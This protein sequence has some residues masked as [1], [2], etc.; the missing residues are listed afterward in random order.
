[1]SEPT[2]RRNIWDDKLWKVRDVIEEHCYICTRERG[3]KIWIE[4]QVT[5]KYK[6]ALISK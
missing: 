3:K 4:E 2:K 1:M 6:M 5:L